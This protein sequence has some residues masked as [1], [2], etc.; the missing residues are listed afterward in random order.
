[1]FLTYSIHKIDSFIFENRLSTTTMSDTK[2]KNKLRFDEVL[3]AGQELKSESGSYRLKMR[4][5][6]NLVG[7]SGPVDA[8]AAIFWSSGT[9]NEGKAPYH[10][11]FQ[12]DGNVVLYDINGRAL[13]KTGTDGKPADHFVMQDD[14]NIVLYDF[15]RNPKWE[16]QTTHDKPLD[17]K[18]F[19]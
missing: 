10:L 5:D 1:V 4:P 2:P 12:E 14:R 17:D 16:S 3:E 8:D 9:K 15:E 11:I 18:R 6:G 7:Y 19:G 13:W